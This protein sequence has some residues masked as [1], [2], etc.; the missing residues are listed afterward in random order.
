[1]AGFCKSG[2]GRGCTDTGKHVQFRDVEGFTRLS[3]LYMIGQWTAPFTGTVMAAL[4]GRQAIQMICN[5]EGKEFK[6]C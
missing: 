5:Q 4:S 3:G 6:S 2:G 1:M